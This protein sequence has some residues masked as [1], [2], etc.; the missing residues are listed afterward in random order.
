VI[1]CNCKRVRARLQ[2]LLAPRLLNH[3]LPY[4]LAAS[5]KRAT[6]ANHVQQLR[7][8]PHPA[9]LLLRNAVQVPTLA[10][11]GDVLH[12]PQLD[13]SVGNVLDVTHVKS[14][15]GAKQLRR[16]AGVETLELRTKIEGLRGATARAMMGCAAPATCCP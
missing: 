13:A 2:Q 4:L 9:H 8:S 6:A 12:V 10:R 5:L 16:L 7:G 14:L 15:D 3:P 11:Q 1:L